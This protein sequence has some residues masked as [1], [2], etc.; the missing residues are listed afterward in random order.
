MTK[1]IIDYLLKKANMNYT[2]T[3]RN[4]IPLVPR[5][6]IDFKTTLGIAKSHKP[7]TF[8]GAIVQELLLRLFPDKV[9]LDYALFLREI[10]MLRVVELA[11]LVSSSRRRSDF[12]ELLNLI[13][14]SQEQHIVT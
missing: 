1:L 14:H 6:S 7:E 4:L 12:L 10:A 11:D 5:D 8:E 9:P 2:Y 3:T 13:E